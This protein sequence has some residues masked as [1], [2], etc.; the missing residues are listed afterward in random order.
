MA[1][2][3]LVS[4]MQ[5][6]SARVPE[7]ILDR[8]IHVAVIG[9]ASG[10]LLGSEF[11]DSYEVIAH[12]SGDVQAALMKRPD[13]I[14]H[15]ADWVLYDDDILI[16]ALARGPW[17]SALKRRSLPAA[18][19]VGLQA[20]GSKIGQQALSEAAGVSTPTTHVVHDEN[21][22]SR[23]MAAIPGALLLKADTGGGGAQV[24]PLRKARG[25]QRVPRLAENLPGLV[26]EWIDGDLIAVEPLY[27]RG[28][29]LGMQYS[30]VERAMGKGRGPSTIRRFL[31]PPRE[32][33]DAVV[34]LGEAGGLHGF[35]NL[36]FVR[37]ASRGH[38][39]IECDMRINVC[40]QYGPQIG[41]DWGAVLSGRHSTQVTPASIG[42]L[43]RVIHLYPRSIS[44]GVAELSWAQ[45]SPWIRSQPGTW[46]ARN[47][48]DAA[49]NSIERQEL[50][51]GRALMRHLLHDG[52]RA[53]WLLL[54]FPVRQSLERLG[55]KRRA[56]SAMG[57]R[58]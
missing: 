58:I 39:L 46:D 48:R 16:R 36:T 49:V 2:V 10:F 27:R 32:V 1:S 20:L 50:A 17:P 31:D 56:L 29:L 4:A 14:D 3:L 18:T 8:D 28:R 53:T 19:D 40:V 51:G 22:I 35:G 57:I 52:T 24:W 43:G 34:A 7:V 41:I 26:Q 25:M 38:L 44:A 47:S 33:V 55:L 23:A 37:H 5:S 6:L 21:D 15:D 45:L 54:P 42:P 11:I 12:R 9:S 30:R 13:I